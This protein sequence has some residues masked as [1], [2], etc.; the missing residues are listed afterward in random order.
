MKTSWINTRWLFGGLC[1]VV[2]LLAVLGLASPVLAQ[3]PAAAPSP[4]SQVTAQYRLAAGDVIRISVFQSPELSL[5]TRLNDAGVISYPLLGSVNLGGMT[6]PLAEK[7]LADGLR[8]GNFIKQPQVS[9][10]VVTVRGNQV[11]V[12]GQ[13]GRPG[14]YPLETGEV[15]L[16]EMLATAGG[17]APTGSDSVV[18]TGTRNGQPFRTEIEMAAAFAASRLN[19]N[20][21]LQ[22]GDTVFV[23]RAPT[24]YVYGEVVR[25]GQIRL[26]R[27]MNVMQA[28]AAGGGLT[29]RGTIRGLRVHRR[30][31]NGQVRII[32]VPMTDL[33]KPDDI[34]QIRE[35]I[36]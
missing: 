23:D 29:P 4:G 16:T 35:S 13:V 32:E 24:I 27:G 12:L 6:V 26:E 9:V 31:A 22:N 15:R 8:T 34:V 36:F 33:L 25:P 1:G 30:D 19:D 17:I 21:V 7:R 10:L 28:L 14:R 11:S 3:Q 2:L 18:V 5:E 20:L